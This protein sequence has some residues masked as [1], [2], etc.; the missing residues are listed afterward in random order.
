MRMVPPAES[1][2]R[3]GANCGRLPAVRQRLP[4]RLARHR[5]P[6]PPSASV[7]RRC[8]SCARLRRGRSARRR[9]AGRRRS[10]PGPGRWCTATAYT[11]PF[12]DADAPL[13]HRCRGSVGHT[14]RGYQIEARAV[15][16]PRQHELARDGSRPRTARRPSVTGGSKTCVTSS[17]R[18]RARP[19]PSSTA[20][21]PDPCAIA[22]CATGELARA[23]LAA[24]LAHR[25]DEQEHAVLTR[26]RVREAAAVRVHRQRSARAR[27]CRP[28]R[29]RR[30][31]PS[32]RSRGPR[33]GAAR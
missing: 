9:T 24:Q 19:C 7:S 18:C 21:R 23:A 10:R 1:T 29:T 27:A 20:R 30:P 3:A 13:E 5:R 26:V 16:A 11:V 28:R 12:P 6:R 2:G 14:S 33:G 4:R 15:D 8:S 22:T 17:P 32:R 31:R 25:L